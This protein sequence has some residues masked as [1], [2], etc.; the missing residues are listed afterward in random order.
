MKTSV[1]CFESIQQNFRKVWTGKLDFPK[2]SGFAL[3]ILAVFFITGAFAQRGRMTPRPERMD[4]LIS[5]IPPV[6][7]VDGNKYDIIQI[8]NQYWF[9]Q[10]LRTTRLN[11]SV[12]LTSHLPPKEWSQTNKPAFDYYDNNE[13]NAKI[14]GLLYNG[15]AATSGKLCPKGW[16]VPTDD[17]WKELE[18]LLGVSSEEI[19]RT[20]GRGDTAG[21]L[22]EPKYWLRSEV[23]MGNESGFSAHPS[24]IR[25][26]VGDFESLGQYGGFWTST[27]Y[28]TASNY[29]WN[30]H[31]YYY[32]N[33]FGRN[34]ILK[35][36]G[37]ACRCVMDSLTSQPKTR[38][39]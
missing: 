22:K 4:S 34:Y 1:Y 35:N 30:R 5:I 3:T 36:N 11:D 26:E 32:T 17:D 39:R 19:H 8:G 31:F 15:Y 37:Y 9:K 21:R 38:R 2:A 13:E 10:N 29:A 27:N 14:Y 28:E 6:Y 33:A 7:D 23:V 18:T 24:G 20:G 25:K 16:R 12:R